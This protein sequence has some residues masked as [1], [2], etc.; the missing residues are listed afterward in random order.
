MC[1]CHLVFL[2][3]LGSLTLHMVGKVLVFPILGFDAEN[4]I[5]FLLCLC[6]FALLQFSHEVYGG[7]YEVEA[8]TSKRIPRPPSHRP[9]SARCA[10]FL[11]VHLCRG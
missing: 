2:S 4:G 3:W 11:R 10:C 9:A 5:F 6:V 1:K 8:L 7:D